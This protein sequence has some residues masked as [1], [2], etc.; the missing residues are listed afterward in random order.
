MNPFLRQNDNVTVRSK[1]LVL[2]PHV[3]TAKEEDIDWQFAVNTRGPINIIRAFLPH[4][5]KNGGGMFINVS[6]L[7]GLTTVVPLGSL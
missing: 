3:L 5:R 2:R 1:Q 4:F 6:S 7:V